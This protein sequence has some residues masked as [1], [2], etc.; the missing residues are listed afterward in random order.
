MG[1]KQKDRY[2]EARRECSNGGWRAW[3]WR[4]RKMREAGEGREER[5]GD[6]KADAETQRETV[7]E[8]GRRRIGIERGE[9]RGSQVAQ[10]GLSL[11]RSKG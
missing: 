5:G 1:D 7:G 8:R 9:R 3:R 10:A 2:M 4:D 6:R 11:L